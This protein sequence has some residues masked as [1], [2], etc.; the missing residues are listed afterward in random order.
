MISTLGKAGKTDI[1]T[2][3]ELIPITK[4]KGTTELLES[5]LRHLAPLDIVRATRVN[6]KFHNLIHKSPTLQRASYMLPPKD[7]KSTDY[8]EVRLFPP[9]NIYEPFLLL[10]PSFNGIITRPPPIQLPRL[11]PDFKYSRSPALQISSL[12]PLLETDHDESQWSGAQPTATLNTTS[13][14]ISA[15]VHFSEKAKHAWRAGPWTHM[16]LSNPSTTRAYV[17]LYWECRV[18]NKI[19]Q[20]LIARGS[21]KDDDSM[22]FYSLVDGTSSTSG[23]VVVSTPVYESQ[24]SS[25]DTITSWSNSEVRDTT[26]WEQMGKLSA[27]SAGQKWSLGTQ[28]RISLVD[29]VVPATE[30]DGRG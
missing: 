3:K 19:T 26:L 12:C 17:K 6:K 9:P 28:S 21:L 30:R 14:S 2:A 20:V 8:C 1:P 27:T 11:L 29:V 25:S 16:Q 5:I 24:E 22:T 7:K 10:L 18:D 13:I 23:V 4:V 15:P